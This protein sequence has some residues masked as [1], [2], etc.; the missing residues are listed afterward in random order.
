MK[1][2]KTAATET[3]IAVNCVQWNM[4]PEYDKQFATVDDKG[5]ITL[6]EIN[7]KGNPVMVVQE[8]M[9][10]GLNTVAIE[11]KM[12]NLLLCGGIDTKLSLYDINMNRSKKESTKP[13]RLNREMVGH[14]S[15]ITSCGFLNNEYFISGS[16]DSDIYLWELEQ[17]RAINKFEDHNDEIAALDVFEMDSNIFVSGS[18]DLTFRVWDIRMKRACFRKFEKNK[19]HVSAIKFM[20]ENVNTIAV[21]YDD[22]QIKIWDLR[23]VGNIGK[24]TEKNAFDSVISMAFSKSGRLLFAAYNNATVKVWDLLTGTKNTEF[25]GNFHEDGLKSITLAENGSSLITTGKDGLIAKWDL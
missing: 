14:R 25:G 8:T 2:K 5:R 18:A 22:G 7:E 24:M 17:Q 4:H 10:N 20:P 16:R 3:R 23:A 6:Y 19:I 13:I 9:N 11:R 21:G 15:L 12:G 1:S